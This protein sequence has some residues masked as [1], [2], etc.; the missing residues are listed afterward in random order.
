MPR[1]PASRSSGVAGRWMLRSASAKPGNALRVEPSPVL[2]F[3]QLG[4]ALKRE[5]DRLAQLVRMQAL[6]ERIDGIDQRQVGE[7]RLVHHAI[8]MHHLQM[9]VVELG[10]ARHIRVLPD[11]EEL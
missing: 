5:V 2:P 11:G 7:T 1:C 10:G 8:G 9:A 4:Q 3:R 6:G